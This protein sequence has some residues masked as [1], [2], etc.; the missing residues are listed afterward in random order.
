MR[1]LTKKIIPEFSFYRDGESGLV[2]VQL[3]SLRLSTRPT[4]PGG[5]VP[6]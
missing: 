3:G 2:K 4:R 6:E 5:V 1:P